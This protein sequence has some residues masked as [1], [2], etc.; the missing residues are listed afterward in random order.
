MHALRR[1]AVV[2]R[3]VCGI[4]VSAAIAGCP[5]PN[6]HAN[7]SQQKGNV[8]SA[9]WT[10][11]PPE[12]MTPAELADL[13]STLHDPLRFRPTTQ[14]GLPHKWDSTVMTIW[15]EAAANDFDP[16]SPPPS[17]MV[18][19]FLAL[20]INDG[21]GAFTFPHMNKGEVVYWWA[22]YDAKGYPDF[23]SY[24]ASHYY[25]F[26]AG[27]PPT[28][29]P[30]LETGPVFYCNHDAADTLPDAEIMRPVDKECPPPK[31]VASAEWRPAWVTCA[32]G[33][34]RGQGGARL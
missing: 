26:T 24:Y 30:L 6:D 23:N 13:V 27:N 22:G 8:S 11:K 34:C 3:V 18:G 4:I 7:P 12:A 9:A 1:W 31:V 29:T 21:P 14:H 17:G 32:G 25:R 16:T 2:G 28:L 33:C 15:P 19:R 10:A 5:G 20:F